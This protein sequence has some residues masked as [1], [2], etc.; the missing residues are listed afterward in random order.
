M[1]DPCAN[2][3]LRSVG[4]VPFA[5]G[6][7]TRVGALGPGTKRKAARNL[8]RNACLVTQPDGPFRFVAWTA[9]AEAK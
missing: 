8:K 5:F 6:T 4:T 7:D 2:R 9:T 1:D 3:S